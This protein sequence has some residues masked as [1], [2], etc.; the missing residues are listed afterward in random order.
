ME[1]KISIHIENTAFLVSKRLADNIRAIVI[2]VIR[3]EKEELLVTEDGVEVY[4]PEQVLWDTS[5]ENWN[6][7]NKTPAKYFIAWKEDS[8]L[9]HRKCWS[10]KEAAQEYIKYNNPCLNQKEVNELL[11]EVLRRQIALDKYST[12]DYKEAMKCELD[13][14]VIEKLKQNT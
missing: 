12:H 5:D 11:T 1:D 7:L 14:Y 3:N 10:T 6:F 2:D 4:D 8:K 13:T 9:F